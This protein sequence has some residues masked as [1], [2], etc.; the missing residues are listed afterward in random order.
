MAEIFADQGEAV[1]RAAESQ[2]ITESRGGRGAAGRERWWRGGLDRE[3]TAGLLRAAGTVVWLRATPATL[4]ARVGR[5]GDPPTVARGGCTPARRSGA[6]RQLSAKAATRTP[7]DLAVDVDDVSAREAADLVM[8]ALA[9]ALRCRAMREL[10][11]NVGERSYPVLVGHGSRHSLGQLVPPGATK[12]A[13][14]TQAAVG[15]EVEAGADQR[16]FLIGAGEEAKS[17]TTIEE[18]V[19][20]FCPVRL[21]PGRPGRRR[22]RRS[23]D[24]RGRFRRRRVP[25]GGGRRPCRHHPC[26]LRST[27]PSAE[28]RRSTC[29]RAK[30]WSAPSGSLWR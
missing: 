22:G 20:R 29:L 4:A 7:S 23:G 16:T 13:I 8:A 12:A 24:G 15:V 6:A 28:R 9:R 19:P 21:D 5:S 25:P 27:R 18:L 3:R 26:W 11:V 10:T 17:M 1:F 30:T 14:V 2:A